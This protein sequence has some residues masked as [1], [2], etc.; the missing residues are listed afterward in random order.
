MWTTHLGSVLK[1]SVG[2]PILAML[3]GASFS[4]CQKNISKSFFLFTFLE[5][6]LIQVQGGN[7]TLIAFSLAP[8]NAMCIEIT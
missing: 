8:M 5:M 6:P 2:A 3:Q 1:C 7:Q 4:P